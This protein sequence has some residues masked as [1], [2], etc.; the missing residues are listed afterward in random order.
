LTLK[1]FIE[2]LVVCIEQLRGNKCRVFNPESPAKQH[3]K[4]SANSKFCK[5]IQLINRDTNEPASIIHPIIMA[6]KITRVNGYKVTAN[7]KI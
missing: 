4:T 3:L 6:L 7:I 5:K 2:T 1:K